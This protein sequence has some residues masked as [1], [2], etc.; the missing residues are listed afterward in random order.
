MKP[1]NILKRNRTKQKETSLCSSAP[2]SL[3]NKNTESAVQFNSL[4]DLMY[5][6]RLNIKLGL[7]S[8]FASVVSLQSFNILYMAQLSC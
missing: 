3:K 6:S 2:V 1:A 8:C 4:C 5:N 7:G